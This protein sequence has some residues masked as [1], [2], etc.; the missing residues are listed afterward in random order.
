MSFSDTTAPQKPCLW[1]SE[2]V[3]ENLPSW[4]Y[5]DNDEPRSEAECKAKISSLEYTIK[6][7]ELQIEIRELELK[8]G[9]SRHGTSYDFEKW[10]V[11]ALRAKQTHTYLLNAYTYW[12]L[13]NQR[14][15]SEKS[16]LDSVIRLLIDEPSDF[17]AQLEKLL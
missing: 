2:F 11:Q 8:T 9:T 3:V 1:R 12:L 16:K 5:S 4:I 15:D 10:K 17:V 7:I 6:D 13:S 14:Q